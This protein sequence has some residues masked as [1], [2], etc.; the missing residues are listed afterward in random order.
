MD[1]ISKVR[2]GMD[3][4]ALVKAGNISGLVIVVTAALWAPQIEQF[5]SVV[6]YFQQL[7]AYMAPP[8]VAVFLAGLFWKRA[9]ASAAFTALLSG[10][11]FAV[12]LLLF[13]DKTP[14]AEW[15]F[16][17]V[18]PLL[19]VISLVILFGVSL[20][21]PAPAREVVE[22]YVWTPAFFRNETAGL[23]GVPWYQNYRIQSLLLLAV[24]AIFIYVWR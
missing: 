6:K 3:G 4:K 16:L 19:F 1:I 8:V 15:N 14:L 11:T 18:A 17:Y 5:G 2:P 24:T 20:V 7:L 22:R 12:L 23:T 21:T 13:R 9:S 10:L